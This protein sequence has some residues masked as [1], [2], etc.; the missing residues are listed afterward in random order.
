MRKFLQWPLFTLSI[1][2]LILRLLLSTLKIYLY[3]KFRYFLRRI[4]GRAF[5]RK[6]KKNGLPPDLIDYLYKRYCSD[7]SKIYSA[8]LGLT[9]K[10]RYNLITRRTR[11]V[12][13]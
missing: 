8:F 4:P 11:R 2:F 10:A 1:A 13:T 5:K 12:T 7:L 9:L 3:I 6:L